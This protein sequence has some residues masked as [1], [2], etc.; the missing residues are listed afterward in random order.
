MA[1][2]NEAVCNF[3]ENTVVIGFD[4]N[5]L[6]K[7]GLDA[8][9]KSAEIRGDAS[10]LSRLPVSS[11]AINANAHKTCFRDYTNKRRHEQMQRNESAEDGLQEHD[12]SL[13]LLMPTFI[14]VVS[15]TCLMSISIDGRT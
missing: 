13:H 1:A 15:E 6:T 2:S 14:C 12:V 7:R 4:E 9:R 5:V 10:L 8:A 3:C 11:S